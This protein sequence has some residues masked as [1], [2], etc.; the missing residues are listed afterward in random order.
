MFRIGI[1]ALAVTLAACGQS[2]MVRNEDLTKH[3]ESQGYSKVLIRDSFSCGKMGKGRHFIGTKAGSVRTGQI[4][5]K[6]E[7]G[8]VSYAVDELGTAKPTAGNDNG[9]TGGIPS[10]WK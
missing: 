9:R 1:V 7:G 2:P 8:K 5:Y 6:K 3:L 10:P 4:C